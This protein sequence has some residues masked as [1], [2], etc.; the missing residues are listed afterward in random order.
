LIHDFDWSHAV[1][2]TDFT[3]VVFRHHPGTANPHV[4]TL[5]GRL[6]RPRASAPWTRERIALSD[7]D[8]LDLDV[9]NPRSPDPPGSGPTP[10]VLL[11]HGLEGSSGSGYMGTTAIALTERGLRAV[12]LNFRSCS[13]EPNRLPRS[14][15][16]GETGDLSTVLF[17][18]EATYPAS[19]LGVIGFSLGGNVLLKYLGESPTSVHQSVGRAAAVSVPFD[20]GA[21]ATCLETGFG[22]VYGWRFLRSLKESARKKALLFPGAIDL[23]ASQTAGTVREFDDRVTAP[24]H[25]FSGAEEYYRVS[26]SDRYLARIETPTL[27]LHSVDDPFLPAEAIPFDTIRENPYLEPAFTATGGHLGF[28]GPGGPTHRGMW[29]EREA[30]RYMAEGLIDTLETGDR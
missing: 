25:G 29:P 13:G 19:P 23:E 4:Q 7:G 11:L 28:V 15:H 22:R 5:V 17:H 1:P 6:L 18:L 27:I 12:A 2:V 3:P 21:G 9:L 8:F 30:A 16:S 14:Y 10:T 20:L 24:V 26:S